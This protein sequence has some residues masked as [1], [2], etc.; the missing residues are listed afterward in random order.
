MQPAIYPA[1]S[2][3]AEWMDFAR[4]QEESADAFLLGCA[5]PLAAAL[6][7]RRVWMPWGTKKKY[8]TVFNMLAGKPGDRKSSIIDGAEMLTRRVLPENAFL[9]ASFSPESLFDEYAEEE[10]GRPDKLWIVDDANGTLTDWQKAIN[11][12]RVATRFLELYDCKGISESF[13]RNKKE[14]AGGTAK[15]YVS[16]TST[17][18]LFGAT[19]NIACFQNQAVRAGMARR[20]FYYVAD[21]HGR[22]I[23]RPQVA[24]DAAGLNALA[25]GFAKLLSLEG[26]M[27]FTN[28]AAAL[29]A[30]YQRT[31][32]AEMDNVDPLQEGTLARLSSAP[33][34]TLS[35]AM[36]FE[37]ARW[38]QA[39]GRWTGEIRA[40]M[41]LRAIEHVAACLSAADFLDTIAHRASV[42]AEAEVFLEHIR[43]D[44]L[45]AH[46]GFHFATRSELTKRH[47]PNSGRAGAWKPDDFYLRFIPFL[48]RRGVARRIRERDGEHGELFAFRAAK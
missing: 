18:L 7:A 41:L 17:S 11:G 28:E 48:E 4:A 24:A 45:P 38:A 21:R 6:L 13:R 33:M 37:A 25:T 47:C 30:D 29:W 5:L 44:F 32:R 36:L 20:F 35:V 42:A 34:Q 46:G 23:V 8:P 31:N 12:E 16:E 3:F 43:R 27:D 39:G 26:A 1:D 40:E 9:P 14:T 19:F 15:R 2:L 22:L 10:G